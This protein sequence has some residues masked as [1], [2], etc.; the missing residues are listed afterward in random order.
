MPAL[1]RR[2]GPGAVPEQRRLTVTN[3]ARWVPVCIAALLVAAGALAFTHPVVAERPAISVSVQ[4]RDVPDLTGEW[5]GSWNDT[6]FQVVGDLDWIITRDGSD[7]S[8]TGTIEMSYWG[9]G[10]K[11]GT[12]TGTLSGRPPEQTLTF[13]FQ[14]DDVG[15]GSGA[16]VGT[17]GSG[18][19][20]VTGSLDF[21]A[22]TFVGTVSD[23]LIRGTFEFLDGGAG[24]GVL[25]KDTP[26]EPASW[27]GVKARFRDG[28]E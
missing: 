23:T 9:M 22:F 17:A 2:D 19:G 14:A 26:V 5:H 8:A 27:S 13:T 6:L 11:P 28:G 25:S 15:S 4:G 3:R 18:T 16:I 7:F 20:T 10:Y 24:I 12:A 21:G 1:V